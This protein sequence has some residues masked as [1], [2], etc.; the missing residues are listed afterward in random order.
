MMVGFVLLYLVPA[1]LGFLGMCLYDK[2][3]RK[4]VTVGNFLVYVIVS[5]LPGF[6]IL[7]AGAVW[8]DVANRLD[9]WSK[10]LF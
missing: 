2:I 8:L 9:F 5:L 3:A 6:N 4:C 1:I 7:A 10:K